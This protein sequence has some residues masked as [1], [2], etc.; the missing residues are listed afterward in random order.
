[1]QPTPP[2]DP[3]QP[4]A[5]GCDTHAAQHPLRHPPGHGLLENTEIAAQD[6]LQHEAALRDSAL[7]VPR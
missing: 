3:A 2:L 5:D 7:R 1:M 6:E 4:S